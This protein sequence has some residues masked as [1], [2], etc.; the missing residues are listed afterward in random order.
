MVYL[1]SMDIQIITI[2][3]SIKKKLIETELNQNRLLNNLLMILA[4][5]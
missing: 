4:K 2:L 5:S 1:S 3:L